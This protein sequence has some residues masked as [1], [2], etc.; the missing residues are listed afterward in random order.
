MHTPE[1]S[2]KTS[3]SNQHHEVN[4]KTSEPF[5]KGRG[6]GLGRDPRDI[7]DSKPFFLPK[8]KL[9]YKLNI[10]SPNDKYE[11]EAD[12]VADH[13]ISKLDNKKSKT[14]TASTTVS[15]PKIQPKCNNSEEEKINKKEEE[16]S[17]EDTP[18]ISRKPIFETQDDSNIQ[19]KENNINTASSSI[20]NQLHKT[21]GSGQALPTEV[22]TS[23]GDAMG[24]NL[25]NVRIHT[26]T[27][28]IQMSRALGAQAF[29]HGS[30]LYFNKGKYNPKSDTGKH[31][32]AHELTHTVQQGATS[33]QIQRQ[34]EDNGSSEESLQGTPVNKVGIVEWNQIPPLKLR[35]EPDTSNDDNII[36]HL[37]FNTTVQITEEFSNGWYKISTEHGEEGYTASQY[38]NTNL[39]EPGAKLHRVEAGENGYAINIAGQYF[40]DSF[41]LGQDARYY[42]NVLAFVNQLSI[43]DTKEGWKEVRFDGGQLIWV[44][45]VEFAKSMANQLQS[46]SLTYDALETI[47]LGDFVQG[48][49]QKLRDF[50]KAISLS[51]NYIGEAVSRHAAQGFQNALIALAMMLV[52]SVAVLAV[53]TAIGAAIGALA[54]GVGAAPGAAMGLQV[55]MALLKWMGLAFLAVWITSALMKIG[56][57]FTTFFTTVWQ[58]DGDLQKIDDGARAFA[59]AI[60]TLI[61]IAIEALVL[62]VATQGIGVAIGKL[63]GTKFGETIGLDKLRNLLQTRSQNS[64]NQTPQTNTGNG[65]TRTPQTNTGGGGTRQQSTT[66]PQANTGIIRR[67][68][69]QV[70]TNWRQHERIVTQNIQSNTGNPVGQQVT[71]SVTNLTLGGQPVRIRIDNLYLINGRY[72]L[73]DA[74]FSAVR[75]LAGTNV[76]LTSTVTPNQRIVYGWI[77]SGQRIRVEPRGT[78]ATNM[79]LTIGTPIQI[80]PTVQIHVNTPT[81]I[82][83]RNY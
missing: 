54:G 40:K 47:G 68:I 6:K 50:K 58:A 45:S 77:T 31:L 81:G 20:E 28:A 35:F 7:T 30:D 21:K 22:Q 19:R 12:T 39:P 24:A 32:L 63:A 59:E 48:V 2:R 64:N 49:D 75:N 43:P 33:Q 44:P 72:Q 11:Q 62:F 55:G 3:T 78:N 25:T 51:K 14:N 26:D 42:V 36:G 57:A 82:A 13:V 38:I 1:F 79:N 4:N 71:L 60:G 69:T 67:I 61:G 17:S 73:V 65:S 5:F 15:S 23:M 53:S 52:V 37:Q 56:G 83:I 10:G 66:T 70:A 18:N 27:N 76:N 46:G 74:K 41:V 29:T 80:H 9:Q 34:L 16:K 8:K